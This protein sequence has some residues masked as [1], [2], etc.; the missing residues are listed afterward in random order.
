MMP[1]TKDFQQVSKSQFHFKTTQQ[2]YNYPDKNVTQVFSI[3]FVSLSYTALLKSKSCC[4]Q[5]GIFLKKTN[6]HLF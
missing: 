1:L 2:L 5:K 4:I 3:V 6:K